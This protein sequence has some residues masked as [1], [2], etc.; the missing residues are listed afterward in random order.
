VLP[1]DGLKQML[2]ERFGVKNAEVEY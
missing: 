1:A 2:S